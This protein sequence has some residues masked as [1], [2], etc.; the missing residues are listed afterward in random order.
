MRPKFLLI[1]LFGLF[2]GACGKLNFDPL[3][4][5]QADF[6]PQSITGLQFWLRADQGV[7]NSGVNVLS[8]S[9][10]VNQISLLPDASGG[11][12][13]PSFQAQNSIQ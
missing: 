8:W 4:V 2:I 3:Q 11:I 7:A 1:L 10:A 9:E 5:T 6:T 12:W 13:Y